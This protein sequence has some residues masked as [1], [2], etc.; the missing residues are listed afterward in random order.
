MIKATEANHASIY[1]WYG[2]K[3]KLDEGNNN[4]LHN[5]PV[6]TKNY[7]ELISEVKD[8]LLTFFSLAAIIMASKFILTERIVSIVTLP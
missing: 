8:F 1:C 6:I 3:D 2:A 7:N 4:S 5:W